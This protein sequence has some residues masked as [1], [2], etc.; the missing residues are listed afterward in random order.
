MEPSV[1]LFR[2][3]DVFDSRTGSVSGP[4]DVTVAGHI[5]S[6]IVPEGSIALNTADTVVDGTGCTLLPGLIDAH[7]HT[8]LCNV[9]LHD[10]LTA[11]VGYLHLAAGAGAVDT[12]MRGFTT[13]RDASGPA[14]ALKRAIDANLLPGPRIYPSGAIIS[15]TGGHGDFR[16][17]SELPHG[18]AGPFGRAELIGQSVI[19]DGADAVL[20]AARE[21]LMQGASQVKIAAG[22]GVISDHDPLD[23][24]EGSL[25]EMRAAVTAAENFGTYVMAHAYTPRSV[26]MVLQA[27][28]RSI[29]HGH[30]LDRDTVQMIVDHDAWWCLQPFIDDGT[31]SDP[32]PENRAK[33]AAVAEG[34]DRAYSLAK[35]LGARV[36]W[37]TD[38]LFDPA[39]ASTQGQMLTRMTRWFTP[40]QVLSMATLGNAELLAMSGPRNPYPG[41]LGVV[42]AGALADLILVRGNPLEDIDVIA[43]AGAEMP[44]IVKDGAICKNTLKEH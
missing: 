21:Q 22:G 1:L 28:V 29:E 12:L 24:T 4:W 30:L 3:V 8:T 18:V 33:A 44:V 26:R 41:V 35:E 11:D 13:V 6:A 9:S 14:F 31:D 19:A 5:V 7:W 17:P 36:A 16:I 38:L 2:S 20:R 42:E 15:Q 39:A 25:D 27:G 32:R 34:T 37:G 23:V 43:R 40:A 10:V